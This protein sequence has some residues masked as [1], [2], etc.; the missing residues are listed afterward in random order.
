VDV[1]QAIKRLVLR[2]N[3]LFTEK[4]QEEMVHDDLDEDLVCEAILNA[5]SI[6]KRLR[7]RNPRDGKREYLYVI[8]GITFDGLVIYT[9]GKIAK[10]E[11]REVFY[12]LVSSK[13]S[14]S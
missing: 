9:K 11:D 1:L 12:V 14:T 10:L 8:L 5:P 7:S 4:A 2:G 13:K 3:V 6:L